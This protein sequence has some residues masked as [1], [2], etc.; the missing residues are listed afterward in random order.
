MHPSSS[1]LLSSLELS[2]TGLRAL[3]TSPPQPRAALERREVSRGVD[4]TRPCWRDLRP[5]GSLRSPSADSDVAAEE[6]ADQATLRCPVSLLLLLY[7][8]QA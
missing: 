7:Y 1:L 3:N 4:P 8:S 2:D 5:Y 6:E